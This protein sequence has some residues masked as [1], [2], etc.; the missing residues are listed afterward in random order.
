MLAVG[1]MYALLLPTA[2]LFCEFLAYGRIESY[3]ECAEK[4]LAVGCAVVA[5]HY[6]SLQDYIDSRSRI[7]RNA[8]MPSQTVAG[9]RGDYAQGCRRA[10]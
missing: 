2:F 10:A 3:T 6:V 7:Y 1:A 5:V 4:R 8:Q 9:A